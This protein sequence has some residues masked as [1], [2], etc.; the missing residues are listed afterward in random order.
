MIPVRSQLIRAGVGVRAESLGVA[1][2][3]RERLAL[4]SRPL[5]IVGPLLAGGRIVVGRSH[6]AAAGGDGADRTAVAGGEKAA[7]GIPIDPRGN[8]N[9]ADRGSSNESVYDWPRSSTP[10]LAT[11]P[12]GSIG[13][14][15]HAAAFELVLESVLPRCLGVNLKRERR[16]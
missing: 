16:E 13:C 8:D 6:P 5:A 15:R 1:V 11:P 7:D 14:P 10:W 3:A 4:V 2:P 12:A 9:E